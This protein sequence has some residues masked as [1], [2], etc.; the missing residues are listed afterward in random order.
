MGN[1]ING[2][3]AKIAVAR[4]ERV[5]IKVQTIVII[6]VCASAEISF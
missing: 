3:T 1:S 2:N 4:M 6:F 5:I